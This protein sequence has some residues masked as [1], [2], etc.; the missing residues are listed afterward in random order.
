[1]GRGA[2]RALG[3]IRNDAFRVYRNHDALAPE[4]LRG[5]VDELGTRDR[6]GVDRDLVGAGVQQRADVGDLTHAAA[7]RQRH[8]YALGRARHDVEDDRAGLVRRGDVEKRELVGLVA[9][10]AGRDLDGI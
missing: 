8:E 4:A 3:I 7:D 9:I 5:F 10:V 1:L 6:G 2:G